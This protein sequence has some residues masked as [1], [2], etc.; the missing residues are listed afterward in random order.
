MDRIELVDFLLIAESHTGIDAHQLARIPRVVHLAE[1]ALAAPFAGY[2]D[3]E[4]YPTLA[5]KAA[6]YASRVARN[7][8]L[9]DGNKR[10]AYDVMVEFIERNG[11]AFEHPAEGLMATA[12]T[13]ERLAAETISEEEFRAWVAERTN[14][15]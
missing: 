9:P 7:H 2:G 4:L 10:N 8:P 12:E 3:F 14:C 15:P 1:S 6:I 13:I 5:D 11:C